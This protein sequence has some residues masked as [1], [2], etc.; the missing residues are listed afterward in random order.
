MLIAP[1]DRDRLKAEF[2]A[3]QP[4]R[5]FT[6]YPFLNAGFAREVAGAYPTFE[7]SRELGFEFARLN[8]QKKVQITDSTKFPPAVKKLAEQLAAPQF[9][10]DLEYITGIPQLLADPKLEGG[11]MHLTGP[12]GRLDV[13][14]D[15]NFL[16]DRKLHRRLNIL[17]YLNEY[18]DAAWGGAVELWDKQV[19]RCHHALAPDLN[20]CVVFE[21]S[22]DSFHGVQ[23]VHCPPDRARISFA[24]YYYTEQAPPHWLGKPYDTIFRARP[25]EQLRGRVWMPLERVQRRLEAGVE[26]ATHRVKRLLGQP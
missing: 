19:E 25:D 9:L 14:V 7:T 13:H 18:W 26:R 15:F 11:G 21:T 2:N 1:L 8:E 4:F 10:A 22:N 23:P 12:G 16:P 3:A 24:A 20:R 6:I 5:W 17:V